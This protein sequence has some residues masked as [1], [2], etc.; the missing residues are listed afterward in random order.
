MA[1]KQGRT[2]IAIVFA[3][4]MSLRA[5]LQVGPYT[6][7]SLIIV[8][9]HLNG[10][11]P[12]PLLLDTGATT[13][14]VDTSV[15]SDLGLVATSSL[16]IV[17]ASGAARAPVATIDELALG[18]FRVRSLPVSWMPMTGLRNAD[19]RLAGVLGSDVLA[20][21]TILIDNTAG[22]IVL[23]REG[24]CAG[25]ALALQWAD[26]RPMV[27]LREQA[28]A[29]SHV[30][31]V[32][33]SASNALVLF[34]DVPAGGSAASMDTLH[35]TTRGRTGSLPIVLGGATW[36]APAFFTGANPSREEDGL[37]PTAA[38]DRVCIDGPRS[39]AVLGRPAAPK[40]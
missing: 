21:A 27:S 29:D 32:L 16:S 8:D 20:R 36:N 25:D 19:A 40:P 11:G 35:G 4:S 1:W 37:L 28:A 9:V 6:D 14:M 22:R 34:R 33:D 18:A 5:D 30:R 7:A 13:T 3:A 38:F 15:A 2:I 31:L 12:Y 26:G 17:T 23:A 39:A 10:R 24:T